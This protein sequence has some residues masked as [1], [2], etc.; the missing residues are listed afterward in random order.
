[1]IVLMDV[2]VHVILGAAIL[3]KELAPLLVRIVVLLEID[4][5]NKK[6]E[7]IIKILSHFCFL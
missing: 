5:N 4:Y 7:S 3:V 2:V 1:M 6:W